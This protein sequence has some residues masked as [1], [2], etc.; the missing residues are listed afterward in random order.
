[1]RFLIRLGISAL[2]VLCFLSILL[3]ATKGQALEHILYEDLTCEELR[4]SYSFNVEVLQDM[5]LYYDGCKVF[6][7]E[8]LDGH[9][10]GPLA[11]EFIKEHTLFV[12]GI[13][14][15]IAAVYNIKCADK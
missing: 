6:A 11:C 14:N 7:D 9:P 13:V 12:R 4:F 10:H 15:D 8:V 2:A 1:M 5:I 3:V